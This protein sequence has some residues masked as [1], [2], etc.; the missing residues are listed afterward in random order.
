MNIVIEL[1]GVLCRLAGNDELSLELPQASIVAD[2]LAVLEQRLPTLAEHLPATACAI[3]E[4][5]VGRQHVLEDDTR[6]VLIPP[7]SGG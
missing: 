5:I 3:G 2:A 6:L 1:H 4:E 7:V